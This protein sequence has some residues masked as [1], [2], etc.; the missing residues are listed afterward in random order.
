M[1]KDADARWCDGRLVEVER[2]ME[3]C[4]C[5]EFGIESGASHEIKG[6]LGLGKKAIPQVQWKIFVDTA[7][8]C[9]EVILPCTDGAFSSVSTVGSR[10]NKLILDGLFGQVFF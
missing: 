6:E 9:N 8:S 5:R 10:D 1:Y 4:P 7:E 2:S 3:L